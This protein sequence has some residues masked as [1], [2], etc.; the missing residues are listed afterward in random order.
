MRPE[1]ASSSAHA[2]PAPQATWRHTSTGTETPSPT[3]RSP[4][5]IT[6]RRGSTTERDKSRKAEP[7]WAPVTHPGSWRTIWVYSSKRFTRDN[8]TLDAQKNRARA[9]IAGNKPPKPT[10][11]VT[12][13]KADQVP[14]EAS[15]ARARRLAGLKGYV[16]DMP[17]RLMDAGE[18]VSSNHELW[19]ARAVIRQ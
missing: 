1:S 5:T 3:G 11:L 8:H 18:V 17:T 9:V 4:G 19:H 12:T 6:P 16:T 10:R 14:D 13:H 7:V 15:L 2:P